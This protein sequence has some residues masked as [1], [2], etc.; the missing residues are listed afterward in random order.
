VA[1]IV[2]GPTRTD[3][4]DFEGQ[5]R[6]TADAPGTYTIETQGAPWRGKRNEPVV[7][8][9]LQQALAEEHGSS[10]RMLTGRDERG[11]DAMIEL[12]SGARRAVQIVTVPDDPEFN[13]E[14]ASGSSR[15]TVTLT[16]VVRWIRSAVEQK[17]GMYPPAVRVGM[18]LALDA[19][20]IPHDDAIVAELMRQEP[21]LVSYGFAEIWLVGPTV[22]RTRRLI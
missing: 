4:N 5:S 13:A 20:R 1:L 21:L 9:T 14:I 8:K 3:I 22:P 15:R 7:L 18:I 16:D 11:E 17:H 19:R 6:T 2:D 10:L 12:Q